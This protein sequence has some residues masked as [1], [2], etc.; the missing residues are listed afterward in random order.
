MSQGKGDGSRALHVR[1]KTA[2]R[3]TASSTRW[4]QRQLNDP[5]VRRSKAE[6]YRS[7][8]AYKLLE[9]DEKHKLLKPGQRIVDLGAA[10]GGWSQVVAAH[11]GSTDEDPKVVSIDYLE[12]D[13]L[14]GVIVLQKNFLDE[15][16]PAVLVAALGGRKADLV[17]S[18]MA[19][20]TTGHKKT[21]HLRIMHLC[22]IAAEFARDVLAPGGAFLAKVFQGGTEGTLLA[23][24][25]RDF[26]QVIH[27]KPAASRQDSAE[28]YVLARGFRGRTDVLGT[29]VEDDDP[30]A[31]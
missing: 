13:A 21:D 23:D 5:Y 29:H 10:P 1:V 15:D 2:R 28:L 16:A 17:L 7:R 3:R 25:K 6:G 8:A 11:V 9:I 27:V 20:P 30:D 31:P 24:L 26:A 4:L 18:D 12:M 19:A 22:E 14:P